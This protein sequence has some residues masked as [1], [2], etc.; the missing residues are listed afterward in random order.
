MQQ[1]ALTDVARSFVERI[2]P[3]CSAAFL[4]GS[5]GRGQATVASDLD[6]VVVDETQPP[7]RSVQREGDHVLELF[8]FPLDA[9]RRVLDQETKSRMRVPFHASLCADAIVLCDPASVA[10]GIQ[11]AAAN[12]LASG[13]IEATAAELEDVRYMLTS[14]LDDLESSEDANERAFEAMY[15]AQLIARL[16]IARSKGWLG[17]GRW[18][19]RSL[20][21]ADREVAQELAVAVATGDTQALAALGRRVLEEAGGV[22]FEGYQRNLPGL[23]TMPE[24]K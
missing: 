16:V 20:R 18:L 12:V 19:Y 7:S 22:L 4:A 5:A 6:V 10:A 23:A 14:A 9:L 2:F 21:E 13:P 15:T 3:D 11:T 8:V 1:Q 17:Q 24:R